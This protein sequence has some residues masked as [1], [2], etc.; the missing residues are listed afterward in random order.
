LREALVQAG[1]DLA[2]HSGAE[3]IVLREATR[4]VGVSARAAYRHFADRDALVQAVAEEA[5]AKMATWMAR[6]QRGARTAA[7]L[8]RGV[9]EGYIAFALDEP[10]W[11]DVAVLAMPDMLSALPDG[12]EVVDRL[13]AAGPPGA[14]NGRAGSG[15]LG[16]SGRAAR[17]TGSRSQMTI[18]AM[19][20]D[21]V[22]RSP[23]GLLLGALAGLAREGALDPDRLPEAAVTCW[24][25]VHGFAVLA[26]RGP[27]RHAP[28]AVID[29]YA[30]R[31]VRALV[32][33]VTSG[34]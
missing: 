20:M 28:R 13:D 10:G 2:R 7:D 18:D 14:A 3:A 4:R 11:F 16:G 1:L 29:D 6:R 12:P 5:L 17:R 24:S 19:V 32:A 27:L 9:G 33:A 22:D 15:A 8:L 34:R 31:H 23:C 21:Q 26:S 30:R 25:G